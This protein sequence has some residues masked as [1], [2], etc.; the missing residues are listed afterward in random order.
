MLLT[1]RPYLLHKAASVQFGIFLSVIEEIHTI[2][3]QTNVFETF[4]K[5]NCKVFGVFLP[6]EFNAKFIFT[7]SIKAVKNVDGKFK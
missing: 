4:S 3:N 2:A 1:T 6:H 5:V 7:V